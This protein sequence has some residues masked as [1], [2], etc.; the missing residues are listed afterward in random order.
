VVALGVGEHKAKHTLFPRTRAPMI[1]AIRGYKVHSSRVVNSHDADRILSAIES[2]GVPGSKDGGLY[3]LDQKQKPAEILGGRGLT[4]KTVL[5]DGTPVI[6]KHYR[7]GGALRLL[8][9]RRYLRTST[10][11]PKREFEMLQ[12]VREC[13]VRAPEPIAWIQQGRLV[14]QGWL[15]SVQIQDVV[16]LAELSVSD[17]EAAV[18]LLPSIA[19]EV[20][21]LIIENIFHVDLHPGNVLI[22]K[23]GEVALIDFDKSHIYA[24]TKNRLRDLYICR[25]RRAVI[26]HRLS[27][28]LVEGMCGSLLKRF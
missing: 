24:G 25:W 12:R 20:E 8:V 23:A 14:Y 22:S 3:P 10:P 27:G 11:R 15:A 18:A 17:I 16:S 21:K 19:A 2:S 9:D 1:T 4:S 28:R 26:K 5:T 13:G 6:I 7:R